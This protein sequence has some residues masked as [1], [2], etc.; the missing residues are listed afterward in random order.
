M[1]ESISSASPLEK[2]LNAPQVPSTTIS[3]LPNICLNFIPFLSGLQEIFSG[4]L[5]EILRE[6]L[7]TTELHTV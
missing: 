3:S 6:C 5:A 4:I 2:S 7:V 1:A